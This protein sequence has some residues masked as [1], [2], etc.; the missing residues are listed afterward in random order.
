MP[1]NGSVGSIDGIRRCF[2]W[3]QATMSA[4][5]VSRFI[6]LLVTRLCLVTRN[7]NPFVQIFEIWPPEG[8][9]RGFNSIFTF[10]GNLF[11][12]KAE[13]NFAHRNT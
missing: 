5:Y 8:K 12:S 13:K 9:F 6:S 2:Y 1:D 11:K 3:K 10:L 7:Q 4:F